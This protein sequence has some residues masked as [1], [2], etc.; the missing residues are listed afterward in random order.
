MKKT[1]NAVMGAIFVLFGIFGAGSTAVIISKTKKYQLMLEIVASSTII[2]VFIY[3]ATLDLS[4]KALSYCLCAL[5]GFTIL[6]IMAV[7]LDYGCE[8][9]YPVP[10]HNSTGLMQAY[11]H[12]IATI[13]VIVSS[14]VLEKGGEKNEY[15]NERKFHA[16]IVCAVMI[17]TLVGGQICA[18]FTKEDLRKQKVDL[19]A[20]QKL[21]SNQ[22]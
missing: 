6:S 21:M 14:L 18:A 7:G 22:F 3:I 8:V 4:N 13:L 1:D 11:S 19:E 17:F 9:S 16:I 12:L 10:P 2:S 5:V 20:K 15:S